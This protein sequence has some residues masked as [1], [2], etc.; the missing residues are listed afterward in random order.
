[1]YNPAQQHKHQATM[2]PSNTNNRQPRETNNRQTTAT[3][4]N[5]QKAKQTTGNQAKR[6]TGKQQSKGNNVRKQICVAV[7]TPLGKASSVHFGQSIM[8]TRN[9]GNN[10]QKLSAE[11]IHT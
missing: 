6:T 7:E 2:Q 11:Q 4:Q 3:K 1:M 8:W 9:K 5:K 10:A